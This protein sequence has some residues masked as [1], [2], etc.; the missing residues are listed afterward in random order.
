MYSNKLTRFFLLT[1]LFFQISACAKISSPSGGP[2]DRTP[3]AVVSS[4]PEN[5][6]INFRDNIITITF[7]EYVVLDNINDK[8]MV[9]PPLQKKPRVY[10]K[11]KSVNVQFEEDLKDSITYT[12]YFLDAIKDL[13]EGN[14]IENFKFVLSTGQ[15]IDSLSVTGNVYN[16]FNLEA[17]EKTLVLMYSELADS[18]VIKHLPNYISRVDPNGY[19]RFDN[20]RSGK[21]KLYA[22]KDIDNS[23]NYN[24]IEEEFAFMDSAIYVT[25]EEN[26]IP[27]VK[28]TSTVKKDIKNALVAPVLKGEYQLYLFT[29]PKKDRYL[30]GSSRNL[31]YQLVYTLSLPPDSMK[32]EFSIPGSDPDSYL[33]EMSK[34]RDTIRIWL[35]DSTLYSQQQLE[36]LV[37][38]PITDTLGIQGYKVDTIIMRY[39]EP[40]A[41][42]ASA[43]KKK[44]YKVDVNITG[45]SIKP[46]QQIVFK[47]PTP[48]IQPDTAR[49]VLFELIDTIR[50]KIPYNFI[51]DS[52]NY[53]KYL[54]QSE[55]LPGKKY[56]LI[57]DSASF[58]SIYNEVTDSIGIKFSVRDPESYSKLI[59]N[60]HNTRGDLIIQLLSEAEKLIDEVN[61]N[62]DGKVIFPL[63]NAD[64]YRVRVVYDLNRDG[65]WTTGDFFSGLQPEPVSYYPN[66]IDLDKGWELEQD[67][68]LIEKNLKNQNLRAK[69][70]KK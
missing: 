45:A 26:F 6:S 69:N 33:S 50:I 61:T 56:L 8:F 36:T 41:P 58:T 59:M 70:T 14:I 63:L 25:P 64:K 17:P 35:T 27:V 49:I 65:K 66:V 12:F 42:R 55:L 31:K 52:M 11:N 54:M 38:Y 53:C 39:L 2:R 9:S 3:P 48:L 30:T 67:W 23:K 7:N 28:D 13:N 51:Q 43:V 16:S 21:Y 15:V 19:F 40:R 62:T 32:F 22:L 44:A 57:A 29:G 47:S 68:N 24:L 1:V 5:G 60:I 37:K 46:G 34:E 18:A 4:T 10:L 20:V